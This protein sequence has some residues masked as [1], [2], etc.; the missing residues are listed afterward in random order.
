MC[1]YLVLV[2][3]LMLLP[4]LLRLLILVVVVLASSYIKEL[5]FSVLYA[6][7]VTILCC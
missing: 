5:W 3:V 1:V 6:H 2:F 7:G 4:L